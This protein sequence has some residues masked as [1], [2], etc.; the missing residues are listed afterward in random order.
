M[1][2]TVFLF[3]L[4]AQLL[5]AAE[6]GD[7][8]LVS[9]RIAP[10]FWSAVVFLVVLFVLSKT[11]WPVILQ[12]LQ[13][14][15]RKIEES[16]QAAERARKEAQAERER[17]LREMEEERKRMREQI[18]Q[19]HAELAKTREQILAEARREA[20]LMRQ[21]TERAIAAA[22]E[23]AL[24]EIRNE[25]ADLAVEAAGRILKRNLTLEDEKKFA[26]ELIASLNSRS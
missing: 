24:N 12:G 13:E 15:E 2:T 18:A 14:R 8:Q 22:K 23:Q 9:L 26:A 20:E 25:A 3:L 7:N 4:A 19:A 6:E 21:E 11:A 5:C 10:F 17:T 1:R 16:L